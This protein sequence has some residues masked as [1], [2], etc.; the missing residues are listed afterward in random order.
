VASWHRGIDQGDRDGNTVDLEIRAPADG[1]VTFT[2]EMG[3]YELVLFIRHDDGCVSVLAHHD[4]HLVNRGDRVKQR[5]VVA[6]M[7]NSGTRDV[8]S[9][10]E[11][12]DPSGIQLDPLKHLASA[13]AVAVNPVKPKRRHR[14]EMVYLATSSHGGIINRDWRYL[15]GSD[16]RPRAFTANESSAHAYTEI[17]EVTSECKGRLRP[18]DQVRALQVRGSRGDGAA[19]A[20]WATD[21]RKST[22]NRVYPKTELPIG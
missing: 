11:S 22:D 13:A 6:V 7:G 20:H 19:Q 14:N 4:A 1:V 21:L 12:R 5:Q 3:M 2:G 9:H 15:Q 18:D 17:P 10:Q 8:H 16:G